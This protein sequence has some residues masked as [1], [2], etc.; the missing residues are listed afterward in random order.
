[1]DNV[2]HT[3]V[4]LLLSR[5]GLDRLAPR[6]G[7]ILMIAANTPDIDVIS[8]VG[9]GETYFHY[10]R[11]YTHSLFLIPILAVLPLLMVRWFVKGPFPWKRAYLLSFIGVL[12]HPLLDL[13]NAYSIRLFLPFRDDWPALD[14]TNVVD[15]WIW[16][17]FAIALFAPF[18]S[19]LVSGEIGGKPTKGRGWAVAALAFVLLWNG[20]RLMMRDR[21]VALQEAFEYNGAVAKRITV[22]PTAFNP[23]AWRGFVETDGFFVVNDIDLARDFDPTAGTVH[24]KPPYHPAMELVRDLRPFRNIRG[25]SRALLWR[26][27]PHESI[28]GATR[29]E[30]RDL[31]FGFRA[32]ALVLASGEVEEVDFLFGGR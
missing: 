12:S 17:I 1:M 5:T 2:T 7:A 10:H 31:R 16:A 11:W 26:T 8:L 4:G 9:G 21:A 13:T 22:M 19:R 32:V 27:V 3:L 20:F 30:A 25:F 28:E 18:L 6:A 29:V 24:Y 14:C 23:L 15:I